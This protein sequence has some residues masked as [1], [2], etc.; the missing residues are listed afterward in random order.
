MCTL[1]FPSRHI[2]IWCIEAFLLNVTPLINKLIKMHHK[3]CS[4]LLV[5]LGESNAHRPLALGGNIGF[6]LS[7]ALVIKSTLKQNNQ[8]EDAERYNKHK[9]F[10]M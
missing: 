4:S 10:Q 2:S 1:T 5:G 9:P 8:L 6:S 7:Q 3:I